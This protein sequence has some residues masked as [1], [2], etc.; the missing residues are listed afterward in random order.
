MSI[1]VLVFIERLY[2]FVD[3]YQ[4]RAV[5]GVPEERVGGNPTEAGGGTQTEK[6]L[7]HRRCRQTVH[8]PQET[9]V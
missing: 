7:P 4:W 8:D 3:I 9:E 5:D 6:G 2:S 1:N